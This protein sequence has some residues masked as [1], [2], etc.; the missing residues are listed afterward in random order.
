MNLTLMMFLVAGLAFGLSTL[1]HRHLFSEGGTPPNPG[2]GWGPRLM[3]V[4]MCT[5]LWPIF[6]VTG[7][8][9]AWHRRRVRAAKR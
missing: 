2:E 9:G 6:A 5:L 3:W 8:Y 7:L 4:T 1:T